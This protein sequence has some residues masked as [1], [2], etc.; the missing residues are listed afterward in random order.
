VTDPYA[1]P[2]RHGRDEED[3]ADTVRRGVNMGCLAMVLGGAACFL[4]ALATYFVASGPGLQGGPRPAI[5]VARQWVG[6]LLWLLPIAAPVVLA[7]RYFSQ[8][9]GRA[10]KGALASILVA[11]A[12]ALLLAGACFGLFFLSSGN[13][14]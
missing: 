14:R 3:R 2:S 11:F 6:A 12:I 10:A 9:R 4:L 5:A 1:D 8:G 7:V 13:F